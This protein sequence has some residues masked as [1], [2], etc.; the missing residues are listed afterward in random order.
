MAKKA[1]LPETTDVAPRTK[2]ATGTGK[3]SDRLQIRLPEGMRD[4]LAKRGR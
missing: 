3:T 4:K 2:K 1:T